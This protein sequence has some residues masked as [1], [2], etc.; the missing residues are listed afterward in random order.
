MSIEAT[1]E[2]TSP[3]SK[4]A[5]HPLFLFGNM[6]SV[7]PVGPSL[8]AAETIL[9]ESVEIGSLKVLFSVVFCSLCTKGCGGFPLKLESGATAAAAILFLSKSNIPVEYELNMSLKAND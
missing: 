8:Y 4:G 3:K 1:L 2:R 5:H 9:N 7:S 6:N